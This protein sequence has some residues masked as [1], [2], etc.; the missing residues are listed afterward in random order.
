MSTRAFVMHVT[1]MRAVLVF[2]LLWRFESFCY[3]TIQVFRDRTEQPSPATTTTGVR[4][5]QP[6]SPPIHTG[7]TWELKYLHTKG[8]T[9]AF[10]QLWITQQV[11]TFKQFNRSSV[12]SL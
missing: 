1:I 6:D 4:F 5:A 9:Q 2:F 7:V 10:P 11:Y 3:V 12:D 8:Y